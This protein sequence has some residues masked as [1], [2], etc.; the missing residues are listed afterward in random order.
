MDKAAYVDGYLYKEADGTKSVLGEISGSTMKNVGQ[1][2]YNLPG[3][4]G[5]TGLAAAGTTAYYATPNIDNPYAKYSLAGLAGFLGSRGR[6]KA[7]LA[8][9]EHNILND[10]SS[11]KYADYT[12]EQL[13]KVKDAMLT[14]ANMKNR[15]MGGLQ[16]GSIIGGIKALDTLRGISKGL[17]AEGTQNLVSNL[18]NTANSITNVVD[19]LGK[20][21][22]SAEKKGTVDKINNLVE[23]ATETVGS[24][25][26][27]ANE[28]INEFSEYGKAISGSLDPLMKFTN[29]YKVPLTIGTGALTLAMIYNYYRKAREAKEKEEYLNMLIK[30]EKDKYKLYRENAPA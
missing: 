29:K 7:A 24:V 26:E 18:A 16:G 17:N 12:P 23:K 20:V 5:Y 9:A 6:R 14:N 28:K 21:L 30:K 8:K 11:K 2:L 25:G 13:A 4:L 3:P 15:V 22:Q 27:R 1:K 19:P 10:L